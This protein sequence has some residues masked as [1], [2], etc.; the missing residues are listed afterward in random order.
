MNRVLIAIAC[1]V[2]ALLYGILTSQQVLRASPGNQRMIEVAGAIQEGACA[3]SPPVHDHRH[4]RRDR[5]SDHLCLPRTAQRRRFLLGAILSGAAGFIGMNISVRANVRT[6]E[7]ARTSLQNGLT[8]AFR[9]GA[10]TGLLVAGLALLAIAVVFYVLTDI[11]G[12]A[13]LMTGWW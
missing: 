3:T 6:A 1:G 12:Y 8:V 2:I 10:V 13:P 5:C 9:A 4:R 7:A 11:M